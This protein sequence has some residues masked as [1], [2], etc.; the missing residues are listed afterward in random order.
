MLSLFIMT[1][2]VTTL[3]PRKGFLTL[4]VVTCPD[5]SQFGWQFIQLCSC[6]M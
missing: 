6:P 2:K 5:F 3:C 4:S 1:Y